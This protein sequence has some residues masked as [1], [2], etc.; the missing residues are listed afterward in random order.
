[1]YFEVITFLGTI[2]T[3]F[4]ISV[5]VKNK[6]SPTGRIENE[7]KLLCHFSVRITIKLEMFYS[8]LS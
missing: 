5:Y 4:C 8:L 6:S 2:I 1:M 3:A 7:E